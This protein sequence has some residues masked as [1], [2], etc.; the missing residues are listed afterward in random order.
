MQIVDDLIKRKTSYHAYVTFFPFY[1]CKQRKTN[2]D[3]TPR[4]QQ[5]TTLPATHT[6]V[7]ASELTRASLIRLCEKNKQ[8]SFSR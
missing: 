4:V 3:A 2:I 6:L 1:Q 5:L 7:G 8:F